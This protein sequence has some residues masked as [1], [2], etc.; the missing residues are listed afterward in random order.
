MNSR[1]FYI[2]LG[3]AFVAGVAIWAHPTRIGPRPATRP[4]TAQTAIRTATQAAGIT[5]GPST[6]G[7]GS[8]LIPEIAVTAPAERVARK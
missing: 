7:D 2:I 5:G 3:F 4:E 8:M 1:T 6:S